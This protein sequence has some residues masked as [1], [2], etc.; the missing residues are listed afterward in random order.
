MP[1]CSIASSVVSTVP[2]ELVGTITG[3]QVGRGGHDTAGCKALPTAKPGCNCF[4]HAV[5]QGGSR[6]LA[7]ASFSVISVGIL[8][9]RGSPGIVGY[10]ACL[11]LDAQKFLSL[12]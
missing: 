3:A 4:R 12:V 1:S 8:V 5:W 7:V 11:Q 6:S 10:D 9:S 2:C